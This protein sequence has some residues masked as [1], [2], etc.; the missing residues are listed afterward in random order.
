M[1]G[2]SDVLYSQA[3]R[4]TGTRRDRR[5]HE[6][7]IMVMGHKLALK[8]ISLWMLFYFCCMSLVFSQTLCGCG[9]PNS[10]NKCDNLRLN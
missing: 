5:A 1:A 8:K 4:L 7:G 10:I 3:T 6:T 9:L 2:E